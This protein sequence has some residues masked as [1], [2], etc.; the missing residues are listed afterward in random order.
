MVLKYRRTCATL[1]NGVEEGTL[2]TNLHVLEVDIRTSSSASR[3]EFGANPAVLAYL[4]QSSKTLENG[5]GGCCRYNIGS[6]GSTYFNR[7]KSACQKLRKAGWAV[8]LHCIDIQ[9]LHEYLEH[10]RHVVLPAT[11][12]SF[13]QSGHYAPVNPAPSLTHP[14]AMPRSL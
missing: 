1:R 12:R 5:G 11:A 10:L 9:M 4:K 13:F 6:V 8:P 2:L 7:L 3:V 14:V